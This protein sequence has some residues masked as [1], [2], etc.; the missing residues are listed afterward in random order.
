MSRRLI[1][2]ADGFGFTYGNN[3]GILEC[4]AAGVV[5]SVSVNANFPAV[6]ETPRLI[7]QFPCASV[8]IHFDLSVGPPL[9][10]PSA[11]P[12]LV[13]EQGQFLGK[14][15]ARRA[16]T[17][18]I[19]HREMVRELTAQ[20]QRLLDYGVQLTHWDS[21]QN[22]HLYPP[23]YRAAVKVARRFNIVRM[24]NHSHHLFLK[25]GRRLSQ[26]I[27][28]LATHPK[29]ALTYGFC[30]VLMS[31]ARLQGTQMAD[32]LISPGRTD[33][34]RKYEREFWIQLFQQLPEG[35][36]EIYCHPGYPDDALAAN[37][38]Y[39]RQRV[40]ELAVLR[41]PELAEVAKQAGVELISFHEI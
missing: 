18:R 41:D 22:Q 5:K 23:F 8:G 7:T 15:F 39:V 25:N 36:S 4:L 14:N 3:K 29:R 6:N 31:I 1:V 40:Q 32:R 26:T 19:P 9:C 37:A 33:S 12:H 30:K 38:T 17:G 34:S 21:H 13:D 2:N 24:R 10:E 35:T 27:G 16:I 20:V 28:H 11:I